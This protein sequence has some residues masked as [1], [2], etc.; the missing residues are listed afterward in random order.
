MQQQGAIIMSKST[1]KS[2][3]SPS[4]K[5]RAWVVGG[6]LVAALV[7][8]G[9]VNVLVE[10]WWFDEMG[11]TEV[12]WTPLKSQ[13]LLFTGFF[14][15]TLLPLVANAWAALHLSPGWG[16]KRDAADP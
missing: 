13:A 16:K 2:K 5:M 6:F 7:L 10:Y 4:L 3:T 14:V 15:A 11:Q 8:S 12:F 9:V 1:K